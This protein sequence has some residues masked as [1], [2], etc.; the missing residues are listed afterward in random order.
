MKQVFID[1]RLK[2]EAEGMMRRGEIPDDIEIVY[3]NDQDES[4]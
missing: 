1:Y 3:T 4:R 2:E